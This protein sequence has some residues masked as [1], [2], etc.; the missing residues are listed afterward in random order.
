[1]HISFIPLR[2]L[3]AFSGYF[4]SLPFFIISFSFTVVIHY[5]YFSPFNFC[6]AF[7]FFSSLNFPHN[8]KHS[9]LRYFFFIFFIPFL[10]RF[11]SSSSLPAFIVNFLLNI[12][13]FFS[14]LSSLPYL[15]PCSSSTSCFSSSSSFISPSFILFLKLS[16][17]FI[18]LFLFF[19]S[20]PHSFCLPFHLPQSFPSLFLLLQILMAVR[21]RLD[22]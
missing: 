4:F 18:S 5:L 7:T 15:S 6:S 10:F 14:I 21:L 12:Y 3:F 1:M 19:P 20:Y 9:P 8:I 11:P 16:P 22:G 17:F 2:F 13:F